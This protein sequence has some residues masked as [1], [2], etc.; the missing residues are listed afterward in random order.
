MASKCVLLTVKVGKSKHKVCLAVPGNDKV[1]E[2]RGKGTTRNP[3]DY[4]AEEIERA[5]DYHLA[6]HDYSHAGGEETK[7]PPAA[8]EGADEA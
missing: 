3:K 6:R 2:E 8:V 5:L 1:L 7:A 4:T